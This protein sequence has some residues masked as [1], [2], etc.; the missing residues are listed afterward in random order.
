MKRNT[1]IAIL[2][3]A[4]ISFL[5]YYF[6]FSQWAISPNMTAKSEQEY[7]LTGVLRSMFIEDETKQEILLTDGRFQLDPIN[8]KDLRKLPAKTKSLYLEQYEGNLNKLLGKCVTVKGKIDTAWLNNT[9]DMR[10][11]NNDYVS[12]G[13][14]F[15]VESINGT[16]FSKCD[17]YGNNTEINIEGISKESPKKLITGELQ[18]TERTEPNTGK[19]DYVIVEGLE[20]NYPT[21]TL[22]ETT[23]ANNV[24]E[25]YLIP[26]NNEIWQL[27][28]KTVKRRIVVEGYETEDSMKLKV[29]YVTRI[30]E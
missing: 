4:T 27:L 14:V 12:S 7:E 24:V 10:A 2:A 30:M 21:E 6:K 3:L 17:G 15:N 25:T 18:R 13:A 19:Y 20:T 5:I 23:S 11:K 1:A 8:S 26:I 22:E 29:L 9:Q 16:D 28:E